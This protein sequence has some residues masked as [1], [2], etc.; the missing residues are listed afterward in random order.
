MFKSDD[1]PLRRR[2]WLKLAAIPKN[3]VGWEL[4][5][6]SEITDYDLKFVQSW[7]DM[8]RKNQVIRAEGSRNCGKGLLLY[9]A[10]GHGKTTLSLA[11]L[12]EIIRTFSMENFAVNDGNTM[13][14]PAYFI[15]YSALLDLKGETMD[16]PTSDQIRLWEGI[17][18][19]CKEDTYNIRVLVIDDVGKEHVSGS[20][21]NR[22]MLHHVLRTRFNNGLPTIVTSNLPELSKAYGD[23]TESF[24]H[25][26]CLILELQ[27]RSGDLRK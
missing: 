7:L 23:A 4:N 12:Q 13:A 15:Q 1:L 3:R 10:P 25:E 16:D 14:R 19:E 18:G 22:A 8:V 6:C 17:L 27:S 2:T 5:D 26:A 11:I 24:V 20:Q 21:W 9:G